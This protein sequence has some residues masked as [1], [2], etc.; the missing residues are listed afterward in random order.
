VKKIV[1]FGNSLYA[2]SVYFS[3]R[4][5]SS[6]EVVGYTVD[7]AYI[8]QDTLSGLPVVPFE[9]VE[10]I[11]P[12]TDHGMFLALSYQQ[13][14]RLRENK[15]YQAK[16]KGYELITYF[17]TKALTWPGL[18]IGDNCIVSE[19]TT[20]GPRVEIGNNVTVGPNVVV[21]HHAVVKDHCFISAGAVILGN[22]SVGPYC[23]IGAN[24]T[25]KEGVTIAGEC[26]I[27]SGVTITDDTREKGVYLGSPPELLGK[28]SD[29]IREWLTWPVS[30]HK[31]GSSLRTK[32]K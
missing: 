10:S 31:P 12:P 6:F 3:I 23:L 18:K 26:I 32:E 14:N 7:Q 5:D 2:E 8:G 15:Y 1:L 16:A 13:L 17:S 9:Q 30:Q 22:V 20:V 4:Y 11:F 27:G 28:P 29:E 21:G 24:A 19:F 25:I